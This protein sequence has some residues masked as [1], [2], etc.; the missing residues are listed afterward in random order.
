MNKSASNGKFLPHS[1]AKSGHQ[2][3]FLFYEVIAFE[4]LSAKLLVHIERPKT[5]G[6]ELQ[7][8]FDSQ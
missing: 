5:H 2:L 1:F 6:D 8:F 7:V 3:I 4:Q